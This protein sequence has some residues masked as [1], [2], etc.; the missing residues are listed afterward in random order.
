MNYDYFRNYFIIIDC[1]IAMLTCKLIFNQ[2]NLS[3]NSSQFYKNFLLNYF[4]YLNTI[5]IFIL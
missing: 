5:K 4:F 3:V 1:I 2:L